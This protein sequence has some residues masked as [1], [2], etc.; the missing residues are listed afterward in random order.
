[1]DNTRANGVI[2]TDGNLILSE[3]T[4]FVEWVKPLEPISTTMMSL[5]RADKYK[6]AVIFNMATKQSS[7][8]KSNDSGILKIDDILDWE[9]P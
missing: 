5:Y 8:S 3:K 9:I 1:M 7:A 6:L 2:I 4:A